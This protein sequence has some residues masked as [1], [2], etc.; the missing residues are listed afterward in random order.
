[1]DRRSALRLIAGSTLGAMLPS[2]VWAEDGQRPN[3]L[4]IMT[5][6]HVTKALSCYGS[7]LMETPNLDRIADEGMLFENCYVTN[8]L[9]APSRATILTGKYGHKNGVTENIYGGKQPFD[10]SQQT[11]PKLMQ[12]AGYQTGL[13]GKWHLVSEPTGFD[14]WIRLP[15]QGRYNDPRFIEKGSGGDAQTINGYVTDI[16]N[17]LT[18]DTIE[19]FRQNDAPFMLFSHHK[20]PHRGWVPPPRYS[21]LFSDRDLP[22]PETLYDDYSTRA[23]P[24]DH[25]RMKI[26]NM[27]DFSAPDAETDKEREEVKYQKYAKHYLATIKAFDDNVGEL[28]DYLDREGLAENT[29]VIYTSD[30]GM[31]VG[32]HGWFDKRFMYE[33]S[34]HIPLLVRYPKEIPAGTVSDEHV[35]NL[36][37][38]ETFLDFAGANIPTDMQGRSIRPILQGSEDIDWRDSI[39]YHYYEYPGPHTVLPHYGVRTD[40]YKLIY[41]YPDEDFD[42]DQYDFQG[43]WELF[44]LK[45]DP[46]EIQN[47]YDNE[48]YQ[49]IQA[50]L[51]QELIRLRDKYE[52]NTGPDVDTATDMAVSPQIPEEVRLGDNYPN[53]FNPRTQIQFLLPERQHVTIDVYGASGRRIARLLNTNKP[54]GSHIVPFDG[55]GLAS[56]VYYYTLTLEDG[57][58]MTK[59]MVLTK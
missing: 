29:V 49:Q 22:K 7:R 16:I 54:A 51:K 38:A 36:D 17:D 46:H 3:I 31:F 30:N 44:D 45:K 19:R 28:L 52:D 58:Q 18:M 4:F 23:F 59:K 37:F 35:M 24:A 15:G 41:Y 1:M 55:T 21:D 40:R 14:Y 57:T 48:K 33:E 11:V 6:D 50:E 8:S 5:D 2:S 56:G 20:A 47:V 34:L 39:Y 43:G 26:A 32:D 12:D 53:P 10:G 25:A 42:E 27:P 13:V 9:C